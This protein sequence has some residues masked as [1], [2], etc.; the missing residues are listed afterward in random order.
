MCTGRSSLRIVALVINTLR[1]LVLCA[2]CFVLCGRPDSCD[3]SFIGKSGVWVHCPFRSLMDN[4]FH[5]FCGLWRWSCVAEGYIKA[6][7]H[8]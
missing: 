4:Y 5:E 1:W 3:S 6:W 8:A 2:P 7:F